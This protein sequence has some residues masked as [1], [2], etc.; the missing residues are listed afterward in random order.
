LRGYRSEALTPASVFIVTAEIEGTCPHPSKLLLIK[1]KLLILARC[2]PNTYNLSGEIAFDQQRD[3][4]DGVPLLQTPG[5]RVHSKK[6]V[7]GPGI[8]PGNI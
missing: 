4:D 8:F 2:L 7:F 5:H 1:T 3:Q 6:D